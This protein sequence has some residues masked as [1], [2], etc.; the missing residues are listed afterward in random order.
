M[1][2]PETTILPDAAV[3]GR[4]RPRRRPSGKAVAIGAVAALILG[5]AGWQ[6][7][8]YVTDGRFQIGTDDAY[9]QADIIEVA[10]RIQGYVTA[11]EAAENQRV[12]AGDVILRI[13]DGD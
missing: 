13:D 6:G 4:S 12:K 8:G 7:F 2:R 10:A 9:V 1:S 3:A 11:V 5:A